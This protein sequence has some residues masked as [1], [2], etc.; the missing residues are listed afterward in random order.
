MITILDLKNNREEREFPRSA[1][2]RTTGGT[3]GY[4]IE[5]THGAARSNDGDGDRGGGIGREALVDGDVSERGEALREEAHHLVGVDPGGREL[6]GP[7]RGALEV[8]PAAAGEGAC[9]AV[10][11]GASHAA[12]HVLQELLREDRVYEVGAPHGRRR[13]R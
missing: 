7:A 12:E 8:A 1:Y 3:H 10:A 5:G 9:V 11:L 13:R 4:Q 2:G 6:G